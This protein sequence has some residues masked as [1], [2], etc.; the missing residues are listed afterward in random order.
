M[1]LNHSPEDQHRIYAMCYFLD[2]ITT[3]LFALETKW[4]D[5]KQNIRKETQL[6]RWMW[7][8]MAHLSTIDI[9][10]STNIF[11]FYFVDARNIDKKKQWINIS[12]W[13]SR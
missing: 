1:G 11:S 2:L 9:D 10:S 4:V 13:F 3:E 6:R 12:S 5:C 7:A 8:V